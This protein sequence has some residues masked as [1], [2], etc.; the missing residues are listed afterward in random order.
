[1]TYLLDTSAFLWAAAQ[2]AKLSRRARRICESQREQL[3]VSVV[4]LWEVIV[5]C[6]TG[7]LRVASPDR[8][9]P[10]WIARLGARVLA[11][12]SAHVYAVHALPQAHRDPLTA[13]WW[14]R[15]SRRACPS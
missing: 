4:S 5:K 15:P 1:M 2:P 13:F 14:P 7:A 12:E 9:L 10:D 11:V 3:V 8:T 6:G